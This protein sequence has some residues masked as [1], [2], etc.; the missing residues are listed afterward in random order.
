MPHRRW[1]MHRR[2]LCMAGTTAVVRTIAVIIA[3][4]T[5][6]GTDTMADIAATTV[7]M[8]AGVIEISGMT[9]LAC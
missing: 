4:V 2:P 6:T 7:V 5:V 3:A 1:F 9:G 8:A